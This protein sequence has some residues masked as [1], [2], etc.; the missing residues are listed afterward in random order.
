MSPTDLDAGGRAARLPARDGSPGVPELGLAVA[1]AGAV[2][3]GIGFMAWLSSDAAAAMHD[4]GVALAVAGWALVLTGLVW[5]MGRSAL[6][7]V[8]GVVG[9]LTAGVLIGHGLAGDRGAVA[10]TSPVASAVAPPATA[11]PPTTTPAPA[12]STDAGA[13]PQ[14]DTSLSVGQIIANQGMGSNSPPPFIP[15]V[16]FPEE[17]GRDIPS[18]APWAPAVVTPISAPTELLGST[19]TAAPADAPSTSSASAG[20]GS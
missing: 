12:A 7:L 18:D 15:G 19:T 11:T 9:L 20:G 13:D 16:S 1:A 2:A 14:T 5:R 17:T 3:Q 6:G 10:P 4:A 8:L